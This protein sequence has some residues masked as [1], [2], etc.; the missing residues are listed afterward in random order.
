MEG[1]KLSD[2]VTE[3]AECRDLLRIVKRHVEFK[4]DQET[5]YE[6]DARLD[7]VTKDL[8]AVIADFL[9]HLTDDC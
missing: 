4:A 3:L 1:R 7:R 8:K 5:L 9:C 2:I 6:V